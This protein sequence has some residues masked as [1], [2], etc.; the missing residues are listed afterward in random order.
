[1]ISGSALFRLNYTQPL[2]LWDSRSKGSCYDYKRP[3]T[4]QALCSRNYGVP[5]Q[6]CSNGTASSE[7]FQREL[8]HSASSTLLKELAFGP[9]PKLKSSTTAG[10][11][12]GSFDPE[13]GLRIEGSL[14]ASSLKRRSSTT[15]S[16]GSLGQKQSWADS[17]AKDL[18][19]ATF[20]P[21]PGVRPR[22]RFYTPPSATADSFPHF[23]SDAAYSVSPAR[24][25]SSLPARLP[26]E[27]DSLCSSTTSSPAPLRSASQ[28]ALGALP[29]P[30]ASPSVTTTPVMLLPRPLERPPVPV[31]SAQRGS[32]SP[33]RLPSHAASAIAPATG[34]MAPKLNWQSVGG[35]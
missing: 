1:M 15:S 29:G 35:R 20:G 14:E 31:V 32:L 28:S 7:H 27:F 22:D 33:A 18:Q 11:R 19:I 3:T 6:R 12:P 13:P 2:D 23:A 8:L 30:A 4:G 5:E 9:P 34:G 16:M 17:R 24:R 21:H 25:R 26:S 10:G